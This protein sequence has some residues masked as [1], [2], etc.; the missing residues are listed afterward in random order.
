M[1]FGSGVYRAEYDAPAEPGFYHTSV[2][3][4]GIHV[5]GS[6]FETQAV[7]DF[8]E[9]HDEISNECRACDAAL[10]QCDREGFILGELPHKAGVWR[11]STSSPH[12]HRCTNGQC[13]AGIGPSCAG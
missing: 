12:F 6:P 10:M 4:N 7:C 3:L 9:Y 1:S 8:G 13:R 11:S 5:Q 2:R